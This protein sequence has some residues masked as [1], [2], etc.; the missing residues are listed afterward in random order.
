[1]EECC[2]DSRNNRGRGGEIEKSRGS[3]RLK[4]R[5]VEEG[6]RGLLQQDIVGESCCRYCCWLLLS[7]VVVVGWGEELL[8]VLLEE[9][10]VGS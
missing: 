3:E 9:V 5:V 4:Q 8:N 10:H 1:V 6:F 2:C 7:V